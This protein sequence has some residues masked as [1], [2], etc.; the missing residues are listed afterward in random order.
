[1][2]EDEENLTLVI[3]RWCSSFE[4]LWSLASRGEGIEQRYFT[5]GKR[6]GTLTGRSFKLKRGEVY[7]CRSAVA[8]RRYYSDCCNYGGE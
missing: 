6:N 8:D 2:E 1:V 3:G 7:P 4:W 5:N